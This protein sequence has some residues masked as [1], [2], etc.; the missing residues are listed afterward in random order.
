MTRIIQDLEHGA[1]VLIHD[2]AGQ[3]T[4]GENVPEEAVAA[5]KALATRLGIV[6][7]DIGPFS[8]GYLFDLLNHAIEAISGTAGATGHAQAGASEAQPPAA[9]ETEVVAPQAGPTQPSATPTQPAAGEYAVGAS[10]APA[11]PTAPA[12]PAAPTA[13]TANPELD[14]IVAKA[15]QQWGGG[16]A[17]AA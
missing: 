14:E 7:D 6:E 11:A 3:P 1:V 5:A 15:Q 13:P 10:E 9:P 2:L 16:G 17:P 4:P 12:A 8:V